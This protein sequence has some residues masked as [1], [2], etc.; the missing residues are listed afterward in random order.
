MK[1]L[2]SKVGLL[3]SFA[4][5]GISIIT[6]FNGIKSYY[7]IIDFRKAEV[8]KQVES[9]YNIIDGYKQLE[10]SGKISKEEAQ[11]QAKQAVKMARYG[12]KDGKTEYFYIYSYNE[13]MTEG[14]NIMHPTKP[15]W[16]GIKKA[17]EI[18]APNGQNII[19]DMFSGLKN[20]QIM[21]L[22]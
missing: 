1:T 15:D 11:L 18:K 13:S 16:E 12:G 3:L 5:I 7:D 6:I 4:V 8:Q 19:L 9:A 21:V 2:K 17:S 14:L 10:A 22:L 20:P